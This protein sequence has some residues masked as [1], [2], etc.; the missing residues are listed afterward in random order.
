MFVVTTASP[1]RAAAYQLKSSAR[2]VPLRWAE[3]DVD[4]DIAIAGTPPGVDPRVAARAVEQAYETWQ[5]VIPTDVRFSY[6]VVDGAA[7]A[8]DRHDRRNLVRWITE[9]WD[10]HYERGAL[11][12]TLT[13]H[14]PVTG[15][16]TDADIVLNAKAFRW[17]IAGEQCD[18]G[19]DVQNVL[20]HEIGHALGLAHEDDRRQATMFPSS[21]QC[22]VRK[23]D[24]DSDDVA[25]IAYLYGELGFGDL[26][27][28]AVRARGEGVAGLVMAGVAVAAC[29]ASGRLRGR[30]SARRQPG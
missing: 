8:P 29:L 18:G 24:L 1:G 15:R 11:A 23:R 5:A 25:G 10:D 16:I 20:T 17:T 21:P 14:D 28:G 13:T 19:Y 27:C 2:G 22:E 26:G 12:V 6:H 7:P 9:G 30:A 3:G 4:V